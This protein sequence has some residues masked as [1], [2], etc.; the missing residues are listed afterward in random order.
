[1]SRSTKEIEGRLFGSSAELQEDVLRYHDRMSIAQIVEVVKPNMTMDFGTHKVMWVLME[2]YKDQ[3][4]ISG[5][6][7]SQIMIDAS[8]PYDCLSYALSRVRRAS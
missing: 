1:M 2:S 4:K 5:I 7:F 6:Q 3:M 8:F